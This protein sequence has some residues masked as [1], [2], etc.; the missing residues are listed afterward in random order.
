MEKKS[1]IIIIILL[2]ITFSMTMTIKYY[3]PSVPEQSGLAQIPFEKGGWLGTYLPLDS[4]SI[5]MLNP[6]RMF[7]GI[8]SDSTG[9]K[10]QLFVDY[11]SPQN[12]W[13]GIH[14]PRNC[15]PGSG[16]VILSTEKRP[17]ELNG[18]RFTAN[19]LTL[20]S[21]SS[22]QVMDF[23]Y[24]CRHGE[25]ANDYIFKYYNMLSALTLK[26]T[27]TA[28]IRFVTADDAKSIAA[29]EQFETEIVSDIYLY[30]PFR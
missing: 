27:D 13:G 23:W 28:F 6:D 10:V 5:A 4:A 8:Y 11:Y 24:V 3:R 16:W 29:M 15:L 7:S 19:R 14:S 9:N 18:K 20:Q 21:G 1:F 26:P 25:T 22:R 17:M 2:A 12:T 30:L